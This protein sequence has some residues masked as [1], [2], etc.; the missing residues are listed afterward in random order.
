MFPTYLS[1]PTFQ[2]V[3]SNLLSY[4]CHLSY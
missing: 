2:I 3:L 1:N 4:S